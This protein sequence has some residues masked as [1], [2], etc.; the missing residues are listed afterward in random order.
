MATSLLGDINNTG[1]LDSQ[2]KQKVKPEQLKINEVYKIVKI[3][4]HSSSFGP[5]IR[6]ELE[7]SVV[8]LPRRFVEVMPQDKVD[9]LNKE[10]L[11]LV[12]RGM[13]STPHRPTPLLEIVSF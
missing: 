4:R 5:C 10:N 3:T 12:Y 13:K 8:F 9:E 11:G 6:V 1:L 7:D 2:F